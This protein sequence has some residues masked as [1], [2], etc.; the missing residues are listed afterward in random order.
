[1]KLWWNR[2]LTN[3][4]PKSVRIFNYVA[5]FTFICND[6]TEIIITA[7]Y[8]RKLS[9]HAKEWN[10]ALEPLL[11]Y[12]WESI[13]VQIILRVNIWVRLY[14]NGSRFLCQSSL[15]HGMRSR[16][17]QVTIILFTHYPVPDTEPYLF[18]SIVTLSDFILITHRNRLLFI[19][20]DI[21]TK[22]PLKILRKRIR[23]L[24]FLSPWYN[25]RM[26]CS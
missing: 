7:A 2:L 26:F 20:T 13:L 11:Q 16:K 5:V 21:V 9:S 4:V 17:R 6:K 3:S 18:I 12:G 8:Y 25:T 1:M 23:Q 24:S 10:S 19:H 14:V 22:L 15:R